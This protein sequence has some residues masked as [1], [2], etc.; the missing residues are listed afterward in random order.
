MSFILFDGPARYR[1][2]P[3]THTRPLADMR[4]GILT[5][6]ERW[7]LLLEAATG[8]L[9]EAY[10]QGVFPLH[11]EGA[12]I[13]DRLKQLFEQRPGASLPASQVSTPGSSMAHTYINS[14]LF[15][16][17]DMAK[18]V[19]DLQPGE[20]LMQDEVLIAY[21]TEQTLEHGKELET[22]RQAI[23][24]IGYTSFF[25]KLEQVWDLFSANEQSIKDD[26]ALITTGRQSQE[27]PAYVTALN[28]SNIFIEP[29]AK[30]YPCIL[31]AV[32]G[33][34]YIGKD[35]EIMDG[36]I[37]RGAFALGEHAVLKMGAKVYG[38]TTIG[39]GCKVGGEISNVV[40][41][42]N[43][44]K[45]HDGFLGNAVI[46]EWCNL[47]ADTNC[48]NLKNNYDEVKIWDEYEHRSVRT[49]LQFC[50]LLMGDH[51]KCG[52]NTMFNTGTVA[53]ISCNIYGGGFPEKFIPSFSW[54]GS[55]GMTTYTLEKALD[56]AN[57]MMVRRNRQLSAGEKAVLQHV[58]ERTAKQRNLMNVTQQP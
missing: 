32:S 46:G 15:A 39:P 25:R 33:P 18:A 29:G 57:R 20:A 56:T 45:G 19:H 34:I 17:A 41:F 38:G 12:G 4:C 53:G 48:S 13:T 50:G 43:S 22:A 11:P 3:F 55:D 28:P 31:N 54:G 47:G 36:S 37:I 6:R 52:I 49:G 24:V 44:N 40:F 5:M 42:A 26:F 10:L 35:A 7:E 58:F 16:T 1:F 8:T 51:S 2:L 9:T 27:L 23:K 21:R 14:T 30:I